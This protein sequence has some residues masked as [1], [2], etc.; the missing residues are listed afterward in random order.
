MNYH[1]IKIGRLFKSADELLA[2]TDAPTMDWLHRIVVRYDALK[3]CCEMPQ[4]LLAASVAWAMAGEAAAGNEQVFRHIESSIHPRQSANDLLAPPPD[5]CPILVQGKPLI[6]CEEDATTEHIMWDFYAVLIE[7]VAKSRPIRPFFFDLA[8]RMQW[9][10]YE[11]AQALAADP[12]RDPRD[13]AESSTLNLTLQ[14]PAALVGTRTLA[15][16][17]VKAMPPGS[18]PQ[19]NLFFQGSV[20]NFGTITGNVGEAYDASDFLAENPTTKK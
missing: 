17:I 4:R 16:E 2:C 8:D 3:R 20:F 7:Q 18:T 14:E 9:K 11:Q 10:A 13:L 6:F 1:A 15:E 12:P 5:E 19:V